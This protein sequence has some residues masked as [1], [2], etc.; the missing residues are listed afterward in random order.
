MVEGELTEEEEDPPS[1]ATVLDGIMDGQ[2]MSRERND[3][4]MELYD[5]GE[6]G[7]DETRC[8]M[9]GCGR[10]LRTGK[11]NKGKPER[12][13]LYFM[14]QDILS[15]SRTQSYQLLQLTSLTSNLAQH[16]AHLPSSIIHKGRPFVVPSNSPLSSHPNQTDKVDKILTP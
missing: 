5:P 8:A 3:W 16:A 6:R 2:M 7:Y 9:E 1:V 14:N 15:L 13:S 12:F 11:R 4:R 10:C